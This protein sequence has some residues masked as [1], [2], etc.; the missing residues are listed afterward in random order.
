MHND[1]SNRTI[2]ALDLGSNSFHLLIASV[3]YGAIN[4]LHRERHLL[5]L[6]GE[7]ENYIISEEKISEAISVIAKFKVVC[8]Q[9]SARIYAVA[10]SAIRDSCNREEFVARI[11]KETGVRVNIITGEEEAELSL[12]SL[13]YS[14]PNLP[15]KYLLFDLGGGST[16]FIF[17]ENAQIIKK[18]SLQIGAVR[19]ANKYCNSEG[20]II[21]KDEFISVLKKLLYDVKLFLDKQNIYECFGMGGTISA[22][23]NL[24]ERN[25]NKKALKFDELKGRTFILSELLLL[26]EIVDTASTLNEKKKIS[27]LV[28]TRADIISAGIQILEVFFNE[29]SITK[30]SFAGSG[31]R[32]G[33]IMNSLKTI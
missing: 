30:I 5:R 18:F 32:E 1:L 29:L 17:V 8:E 23:A 24:I 10:T 16:E 2:A 19:F 22:T 20:N 28:E 4:K 31:L 12:L 21:N 15:E 26:K 7:G 6:R 9:F 3:N 13:K 14:F 27:G 25:I 11:E 33:I